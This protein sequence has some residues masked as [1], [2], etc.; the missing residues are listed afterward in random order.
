MK[1]E[2]LLPQELGEREQ[3]D[4]P[5]T[6]EDVLNALDSC[7]FEDDGIHKYDYII[8]KRIFQYGYFPFG[9]RNFN[10]D[11]IH[12]NLIRLGLIL[13]PKYGEP[14]FFSRWRRRIADN[15]IVLTNEGK[16]RLGDISQIKV[17]ENTGDVYAIFTPKRE[18]VIY[19]KKFN[20]D[21]GPMKVKNTRQIGMEITPTLSEIITIHKEELTTLVKAARIMEN[22]EKEEQLA[23]L[24][25]ELK[26]ELV[27]IENLLRIQL[28]DYKTSIYYK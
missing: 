21:I 18:V 19:A 9:I 27:F 24:I 13:F 1:N 14:D 11:P 16:Y 20:G 3:Q 17:D 28:V 8:P 7:P 2:N 10:F 4:L 23:E 25:P 5:F 15:V 26:R 22:E 12:L 6:I